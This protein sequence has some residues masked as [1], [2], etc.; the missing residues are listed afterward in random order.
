MDN[1]TR[2]YRL[3]GVNNNALSKVLGYQLKLIIDSDDSPIQS[4]LKARKLTMHILIAEDDKDL[5]AIL[6]TTLEIGGY[7]VTSADDGAQALGL[8][9]KTAPD[10]IISDILMPK[11]DGYTLCLELKKD[12]QLKAIP[13]ILYTA[14]YIDEKDKELALSM[15]VSRFIIKPIEM[16]DLLKIIEEVL[17]EHKGDKSSPSEEL[18]I[19]SEALKITHAERL[20][21]KLA[22]K[23]DE[24]ERA[25]SELQWHRDH[26]EQL[27]EKKTADLATAKEA[28]EAANQAKSIFLA[29]ISHELRTPMHAILN[30]SQMGAGKTKEVG[31]EKLYHYFSCIDKS[32]Q[33]LLTLLNDLLDLSKLEAGRDS[34]ILEEHD[35]KV[36]AKTVTTELN[37]LAA[38]KQL[39][40]KILP[41][42]ENTVAE[43]D[44]DKILQVINN[45]LS[46]AIK[47]SP[48]EKE[49]HLSFNST[50]LLPQKG[51]SLQENCSAIAVN[52][53]DQGIGIPEV[54]QEQVFDRFVQSSMTDTGSG[55][56]GL[57]L[58]ICKEIIKGHNGTIFAKNNQGEGATFTFIIPR[59]Q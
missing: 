21:N 25:N 38:N 51:P 53:T 19:N 35:L 45:I 7:T 48:E 14:T 22:E 24:L 18:E 33:R 44:S 8:A 27:V 10:L 32:G 16:E 1:Q 28:A 3:F 34:F 58:A 12:P 36:L 11:M 55:G 17:Q 40:L 26:L 2:A 29:N 57:G 37:S 39:K 46:N 30:F 9:K 54:E 5:K 47:F 59:H 6:E 50:F 41:T 13:L 43:V 49:I 31:Q 52:I 20:I 4:R 15:G 56:T 23:V 42:D